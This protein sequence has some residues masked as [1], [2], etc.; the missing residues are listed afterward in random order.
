MYK[1]KVIIEWNIILKES[2]VENIINKLREKADGNDYL[3][4]ESRGIVQL[5]P[6]LNSQPSTL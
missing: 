1:N 5:F 4:V 6:S 2:H 3:E